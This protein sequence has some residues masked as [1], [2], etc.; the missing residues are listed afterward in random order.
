MATTRAMAR[1]VR[2]DGVAEPC[3]VLTT[4]GRLPDELIV[5]LTRARTLG[6]AEPRGHRT[7]RLQPSSLE[8][9]APTYAEVFDE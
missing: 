4:D 8:D 1:V 9:A 7:Y 6:A 3:L 5:D 2:L